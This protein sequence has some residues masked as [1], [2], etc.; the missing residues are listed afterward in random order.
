MPAAVAWKLTQLAG[1]Q[2]SITL[3]GAAAPHGR[4]RKSPV[5][6]DTL[7]LRDTAQYYPGRVR[8]TRHIFGTRVDDIV[9]SGRWMDPEL[10][11]AGA[12]SDLLRQFQAFVDDALPCALEWGNIA[13]WTGLLRSVKGER[14]SASQIAWTLTFA[15]DSS[16]TLATPPVPTP[17]K[18]ASDQ[19]EQITTLIGD[20]GNNITP[21]L[22][23]DIEF[24]ASFLESLD[25][26]ISSINA[27]TGLLVDVVNGFDSFEKA[28][29]SE[30][31]RLRGGIGQLKTAVITLSNTL[32]D[33]SSDFA[34]ERSSA[35]SQT[36]WAL[37]R[38]RSRDGV[39]SILA[40]LA[41]LD[42]DAE[43]ALRGKAQKTIRA[44]AGDTWESLAIQYYGGVDKADALRQAN[45]ARYGELPVAGRTLHA[46]R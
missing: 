30:L 33:A 14:E 38:E 31:N 10:G 16:D 19:L 40:F 21:G 18:T 39:Q 8:P 29:A 46:P 13:A 3:S 41:A 26:S 35:N 5:V 42:A 27:V 20:G 1:A 32:D 7:S 15:V 22:P 44:Q 43:Q 17:A 11:G 2:R 34:I 37:E 23:R 4:P 28:A 24:G 36:R 6:V 9:L 12:A 45:G 25:N